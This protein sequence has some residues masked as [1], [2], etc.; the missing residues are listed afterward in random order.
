MK[1]CMDGDMP[2]VGK[3]AMGGDCEYCSYAKSRTELTLKAL[4]IRKKK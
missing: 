4:E 2:A 3:A 1:K